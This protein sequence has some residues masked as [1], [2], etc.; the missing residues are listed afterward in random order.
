MN[1]FLN[2]KY[3]VIVLFFLLLFSGF[4]FINNSSDWGFYGHRKINRMAVFTLPPPM[5]SFFKKNIEYLTDHAVDPDKRRYATKHEAVRHYID[6]DIWEEYPFDTLPRTMVDALIKYSKIAVVDVYADT[7][8]VL[9]NEWT[10]EDETRL[11]FENKENVTQSLSKWKL[12]SFFYNNV[13]P[14]YYDDVWEID[15]DSF[16]LYFGE[17]FPNKNCSKVIVTDLFSEHGILPY[18][19]ASM[20]KRLTNAFRSKNKKSILR[21]SAEMGHYI[22]DAHVPLH[23]TENYNGQLTDQIGIH[24]FWESRIPELLAEEEY[25]FFVGKANYIDDPNAY[26]WDIIEESHLLVDSVLSIEKELSETFPSD[27]QYCFE[28][29]N[30]LMVRQPCKA[31]AMAFAQKMKGMVEKRMAA[32]VHALGSVWYTAW[33]DAGQPDLMDLEEQ[34]LTNEELKEKQQLENSYKKNSIKGRAH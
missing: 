9:E 16:N 17:I 24:G 13:M 1:S 34:P 30:E 21:L 7:L 5:I 11:F 18:H 32:T 25:D 12:R 29:R 33:V 8:K 27:Q 23:T 2:N 6:I 26:F 3:F 15:C 19:L 14:K 20:Q 28:K 22:G 10:G 31:Y 4:S